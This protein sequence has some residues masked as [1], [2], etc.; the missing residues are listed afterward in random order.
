LAGQR[1][2]WIDQGQ[3]LNLFFPANAEPKY[4]HEVHM[5]AHE[6]GLNSLYY[7]RS[8]SVL[9]GDAGTREYKRE[10]D[11]CKACEG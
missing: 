6:E 10:S 5:M 2:K 11:E 4:V 1:Q 7:L 9:K 8:S 3:S